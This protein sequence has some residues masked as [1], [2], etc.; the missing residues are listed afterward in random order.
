MLLIEAGGRRILYSGDFRMHGR[1]STLVARLMAN[2]PPDIDVLLMEGT[3]LGSDKSTKS[4][5]ELEED[6][7]RLFKETPGRVF[8]AWSAQNID[9]TVTL[10]RACLK[11]DRT[12]VVDL[13]T[14]EVLD[15]LAD[16]GRLPRAGWRNLKVVV[17]RAFS[18][19]YKSKGRG[20]FVERMAAHGISA[21][22]L[23][24]NQSK[25]VVMIRPSLIADL[26]G[27]SVVPTPADAWSYSMWMG[28]LASA[29]GQ[30]LR[31]WFDAGGSRAVIFTP[32]AT[33]LPPI[34]V[35]SPRRSTPRGWCRSTAPHGTIISMAFRPCTGSATASRCPSE[36]NAAAPAPLF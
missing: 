20:D 31:S 29:D 35:P 11:T 2:P 15:I 4:E 14:A 18:R 28:Y 22:R 12:L 17:T 27:K 1:K 7:V 32:A 9:R 36:S 3:N 5:A 30:R 19:L 33:L 6:F 26:Q 23:A 10:Y 13:Y 8:V 21:A 34:F 24:E 16:M 25:W